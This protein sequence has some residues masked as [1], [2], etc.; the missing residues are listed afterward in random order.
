M[1]GAVDAGSDCVEG[2]E[3]LHVRESWTCT[4]PGVRKPLWGHLPLRGLPIRISPAVGLLGTV[5]AD[6]AAR[7]VAIEC[8]SDL[9]EPLCS[10][11]APVGELVVSI[12]APRCDHGE[13]E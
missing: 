2:M 11:L 13:H 10:Q 1:E 6:G 4:E 7:V 3:S 9:A 12:P 8:C 5:Y